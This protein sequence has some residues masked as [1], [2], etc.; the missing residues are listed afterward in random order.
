MGRELLTKEVL[1]GVCLER[2][3]VFHCKTSGKGFKYNCLE[4]GPCL[5]GRGY[6]NHL[7]LGGGGG[8]GGGEE[9]HFR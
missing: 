7:N 6:V 8:G 2:G 5:S 3:G 9:V 1:F 4:R